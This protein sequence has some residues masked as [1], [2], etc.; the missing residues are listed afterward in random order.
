MEDTALDEQ[1]LALRV[2]GRSFGAIATAVGL[3][4]P[5]L[6]LEAFQRALRRRPPDRR[7]ALRADELH[8]LGTVARSLRARSDLDP[9]ALQRQLAVL[10]RLRDLI[11]TD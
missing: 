1:V 10:D 2:Q 9:E 7:A 6:A 8:R 3:D 11:A 4:R 5:L